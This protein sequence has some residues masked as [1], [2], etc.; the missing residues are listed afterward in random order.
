MTSTF[1][2][3]IF[4]PLSPCANPPCHSTS[5]PHM[6]QISTSW[7]RSRSSIFLLTRSVIFYS[8]I[9]PAARTS[10][11]LTTVDKFLSQ[12]LSSTRACYG[13]LATRASLL[14]KHTKRSSGEFIPFTFVRLT[15]QGLLRSDA[16]FHCR[17]NGKLK[18]LPG[19][20]NDTAIANILSI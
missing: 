11:K 15:F 16:F 9:A 13:S 17:G 14:C 18:S 20:A 8:T 12:L 10:D 2:F 6:H 5:L 3:P 4:V 7:L 1:D 19:V